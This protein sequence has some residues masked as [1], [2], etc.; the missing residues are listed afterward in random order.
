MRLAIEAAGQ[1]RFV[2]PPNPWVGAVVL[3][4]DGSIYSGSTQS[5]GGDHAEVVAIGRAGK[6]AQGATLAVTLEP[7]SH[8]GRT[9]PCTNAILDAGIGRVV[10]GI[11]DPDEKVSGE[12]LAALETAGVACEVGVLAEEIEDQLRPYVHHRRTGRPYVVAKFGISVDGKTAAP[13]GTSKWITGAAARADTHR[14]RAES[15][16]IAVGAGTVRTDDPMLTVRDF[17]WDGPVPP[18]GLDPLRYVFGP[19][20]RGARVQPCQEVKANPA[21]F[22]SQLGKEGTLQLMI[23]GGAGL[24]GSFHRAELI[25]SYVAYVAPCLFG[26]SDATGIFRG[27]G[28]ET[29]A[30]VWRGQF[31][32]VSVLDGDLRIELIRPPIDT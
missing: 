22:V 10:V 3:T 7:C 26:G 30:E 1:A 12:G 13:D 23:E 21:E 17:G 8:F 16:A 32:S 15:Q 28:A 5:P 29:I 9:P 20:P 31:R 18:S 25:D 11:T 27:S 4:D 24:M 19:V 6:A 2:A 14:L